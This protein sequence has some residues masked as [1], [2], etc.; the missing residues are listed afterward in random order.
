[1]F[2]PKCNS[3]W[4]G[5]C[6]M[7]IGLLNSFPKAEA[8]AA[9]SATANSRRAK[10][11]DLAVRRINMDRAANWCECVEKKQYGRDLP[12]RRSTAAIGTVIEKGHEN[13]GLQILPRE[14]FRIRLNCRSNSCATN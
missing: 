14:S 12:G 6:R 10:Q 11:A 4:G 2:T 1:M 5:N 7:T 3:A 13:Q 8:V 9:T